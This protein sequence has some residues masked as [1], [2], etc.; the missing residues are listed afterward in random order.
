MERATS[1]LSREV[2]FE[3]SSEFAPRN[4]WSLAGYKRRVSPTAT[5]EAWYQHPRS[6]GWPNHHP[7]EVQG[8]FGDSKSDLQ[9]GLAAGGQM[10]DS[11]HLR[12][13]IV[14]FTLNV[15][16]RRKYIKTKIPPGYDVVAFQAVESLN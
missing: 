11:P 13:P 7:L 1:S 16:E 10:Y 14:L 8:Y 15:P 2:Y 9:V 4:E 3:V 12:L 6:A 5:I